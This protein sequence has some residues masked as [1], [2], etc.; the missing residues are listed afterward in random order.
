MSAKKLPAWAEAAFTACGEEYFY[1]WERINTYLMGAKSGG[2]LREIEAKLPALTGNGSAQAITDSDWQRIQFFQT[3]I[4]CADYFAPSGSAKSLE[5]RPSAIKDLRTQKVE[6][7]KILWYLEKLIRSLDLHHDASSRLS[8]RALD[9][10]PLQIIEDMDAHAN[11]GEGYLRGI[12]DEFQM[13]MLRR[14]PI[15]Q[16]AKDLSDFTKAVRHRIETSMNA[17]S[18][19]WYK[20]HKAWLGIEGHKQASHFFAAIDEWIARNSNTETDSLPEGFSLSDKSLSELGLAFGMLKDDI[21]PEEIAIYRFN[22]KTSLMDRI[23]V[24]CD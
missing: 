10:D 14:G 23:K 21:S 2:F 1:L 15:L 18:E 3:V 12:R 19:H 11:E 24:S 22:R 7:K 20:V 9:C 4:V 17:P 8:A 16:A 5:N 13:L 6:A